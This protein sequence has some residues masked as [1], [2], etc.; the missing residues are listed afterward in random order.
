MRIIKT[1]IKEEW[2]QNYKKE[3]FIKCIV[4]HILTICKFDKNFN[5]DDKTSGIEES[6]QITQNKIKNKDELLSKSNDMR[7]SLIDKISELE[8]EN[9]RM[10]ISLLESLGAEL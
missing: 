7:K 5:V 9:F 4:E 10:K 3:D 8:N 6:I 1:N 2:E